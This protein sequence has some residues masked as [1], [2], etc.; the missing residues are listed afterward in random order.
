M[1][2]KTEAQQQ[3]GV[4]LKLRG[5]KYAQAKQ[6][7]LKDLELALRPGTLTVITGSSGSGKSTL[8][9]ILA[10]MLPRPGLDSLDATLVVDGQ[11]VEHTAVSSPRIDTSAWAQH[12]GFLPQDPGEYLSGIRETVK[13]ELVFSLENRGMPREMMEARLQSVVNQFGIAH[14]LNRDPAKLSGGQER[15][16]ALAALVMNDPQVLVLDEPLAGLD[17][18]VRKAVLKTISSL[19]MTEKTVV[20]LV[21]EPIQLSTQADEVF[22]LT[23]NTLASGIRTGAP[24]KVDDAWTKVEAY[25]RPTSEILLSFQT[26][27]VG[28]GKNSPPIVE[29]FSLDVRAGECVELTGPNGSG[30]T[31]LLKSAAGLIVPMRGNLSRN[32]KVGMLLQNPNDQLFER[33]VRRDVGY[34]LPKG[35]RSA[36]KIE[37]VLEQLALTDLSDVHP[38]ELPMS[39]RKLVALA[40]VL[41]HE[42]DILLMD[43]PEETLDQRDALTLGSAVQ[44]HTDSGGS[45][46]LT[47]HNAKK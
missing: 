17:S 24:R 32:G 9:A 42:P 37:E 8:G 4:D 47:V 18:V 2:D 23:D 20:V 15:L 1:S 11:T 7:I 36:S 45:V 26:V 21:R 29:N 16:V 25:A 14:L 38:Y 35:R 33:T 6:P 31:T 19:T 39:K 44:T 43:E 30:K 34:G 46:L 22:C 3:S 41:V 28:Y 10:G 13:E 12:I 5:F 40:G 27:S